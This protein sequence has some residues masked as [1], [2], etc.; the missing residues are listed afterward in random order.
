MSNIKAISKLIAGTEP[1]SEQVQ[2]VQAIAHGLNIPNNDAMMPILIA[3]EQYH[4]IF[5]ALPSRMQS[6][7]NIT[8]QNAVAQSTAAINQAVA[9]AVTNLGPQVGEA[10]VNVAKEYEYTD[11]ARWIACVIAVTY[12]VLAGF[13]WWMH[14]IGVDSGIGIGYNQAR[15]ESAASAW[16]N[17]S[18]GKSA[19][20][21]ARAVGGE[22]D[23]MHLLKCD[24]PGWKREEKTCYPVAAKNGTY[25][26]NLN[27]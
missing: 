13:G 17:T 9:R 10:I 6:A 2:R 21:L 20:K 27:P 4:G 16:A 19:Y 11:R 24:K 23:L 26:W 8:A 15:D 5:S 22:A 18:E 25:G 7:A 3:L 14:T 12:F 1:T